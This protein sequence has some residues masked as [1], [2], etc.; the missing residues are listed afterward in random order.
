MSRKKSLCGG[1]GALASSLPSPALPT[2]QQQPRE[3]KAPVHLLDAALMQLATG[4]VQVVMLSLQACL[5]T[6]L[7][8]QQCPQA[9]RLLLVELGLARHLQFQQQ[10]LV[11]VLQHLHPLHIG[12][13]VVIQLTQLLLLLHKPCRLGA[14]WGAQ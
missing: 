11:V 13:K 3:A 14:G 12:G 4:L 5:L 9:T 10:H 6:P 7:S 1:K 2:T 8:L